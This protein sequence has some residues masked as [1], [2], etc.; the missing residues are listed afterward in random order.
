MAASTSDREAPSQGDDG[1]APSQVSMGLPVPVPA[2]QRGKS[3]LTLGSD[4]EEAP[5]QESMGIP[6][7]VLRGGTPVP[8]IAAAPPPPSLWRTSA[9][10][11]KICS[12]LSLFFAPKLHDNCLNCCL[13]SVS[14]FRLVTA[15][16]PGLVPCN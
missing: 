14:Y 5:S 10:I 9:H 6:A 7:P 4:G 3:S 13:I 16:Y 8:L 2:L 15:A 12:S 1:Q 11:S